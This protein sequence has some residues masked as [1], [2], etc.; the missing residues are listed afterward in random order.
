MSEGKARRVPD[1]TLGTVR[2]DRHDR[3]GRRARVDPGATLVGTSAKA[4]TPAAALA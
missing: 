3:G 2:G 4:P 1:C